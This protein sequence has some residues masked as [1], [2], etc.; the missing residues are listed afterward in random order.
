MKASIL[1]QHTS[2]IMKRPYFTRLLPF[3]L[4]SLCPLLSQCGGAAEPGTETGNPPRVDERK[5][6]L[7]EGTR[8]VELIGQ[9]GAVSPG[10]ATLRVENLRTGESVEVTVAADGSVNIIVPGSLQDEYSI[11]VSS[12]GRT[13]TA[14][15]S[16][17]ANG[18]AGGAGASGGALSCEVLENTMVETVA[19][20]F[21]SA[22]AQACEVDSD[23]VHT[24]WSVGCYYQCGSSFVSSAGES[25]ARSLA[26]QDTAAICAELDGRRCPRPPPVDCLLGN[27]VP[28]CR[29]GTCQALD[30]SSLTCSEL[31][32]RAGTQLRELLDRAD[33]TCSVDSDCALVNHSASCVASCGNT[34]SVANAAVQP[35]SDAVTFRVERDICQPFAD[36]P[37]EPPVALPCTPPPGETASICNAGQCELTFM[38]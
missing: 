10:G 13:V 17:P 4:I 33:R 2:T 23:C 5:L 36:R 28:E 24:F 1:A 18:G 25:A 34:A 20:R 12:G 8:G 7:V 16:G 31:S 6:H 30:Q 9:P 29:N 27:D 22:A 32:L 21:S 11:T 37:C 15:V 14:S 35:L 38:E 26:E 3:L 19:G